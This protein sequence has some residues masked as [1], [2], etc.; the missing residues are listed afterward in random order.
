[1]VKIILGIILLGIYVTARYL[2]VP[3]DTLLA[4]YAGIMVAVIGLYTF[5][6]I[7]DKREEK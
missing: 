3:A 5:L 2:G 6:E 1:M 7:M 4:F